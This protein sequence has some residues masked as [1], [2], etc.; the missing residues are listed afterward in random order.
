MKLFQWYNKIYSLHSP[1][2]IIDPRLDAFLY[3]I[4]YNLHDN[5]L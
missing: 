4:Y 5:H 3:Y 2:H 1:Y